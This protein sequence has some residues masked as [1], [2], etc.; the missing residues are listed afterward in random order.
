[1]HRTRGLPAG[2]EQPLVSRGRGVADTA[3]IAESR[4]EVTSYSRLTRCSGVAVR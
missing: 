4:E 3:N 2:S 1:M